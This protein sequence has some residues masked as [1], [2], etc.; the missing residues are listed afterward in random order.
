MFVR[1]AASFRPDTL[2][3]AVSGVRKRRRG[4]ARPTAATARCAPWRVP[5]RTREA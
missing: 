2:Q 1:A 4:A 5:S 3:E